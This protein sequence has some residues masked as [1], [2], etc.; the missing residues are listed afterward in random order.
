MKRIIL[1]RH[2][3]SDWDDSSLSDY[4]RPLSERGLKDAPMMAKKFAKRNINVDLLYSSSANRAKST[5][6][7]FI[8]ELNLSENQYY[9]EREIYGSGV[10][11]V[12]NIIPSLDNKVETV[13]FFGHNPDFT[14][15]VTYFS[16]ERIGNLP[17][18]GIAIIKFDLS[19]WSQI[20]DV[21][22]ELEVF[23]FPK[24]YTGQGD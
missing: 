5:A 13:M 16:G 8:N 9:F 10:S 4:Q 23:D 21:N 3:K 15:L 17:T 2:A 6:E 20:H 1:N 14:S 12:R 22:G 19:S 18:C 7:Y 24:N 11:F